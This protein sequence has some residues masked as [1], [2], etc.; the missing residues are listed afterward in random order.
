MIV[1]RLF[2]VETGRL[3]RDVSTTPNA[4]NQPPLEATDDLRQQIR[5]ADQAV[6]CS[7]LF[8]ALK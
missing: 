6:G 8:G 3:L 7:G 1:K 5:L 4:S 2:W